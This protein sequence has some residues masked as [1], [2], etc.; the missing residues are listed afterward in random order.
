M[1]FSKSTIQSFYIQE[2]LDNDILP[3]LELDY[4]VNMDILQQASRRH[5]A[6]YAQ[7]NPEQKCRRQLRFPKAVL[8]SPEESPAQ[9]ILDS[10]C[11]QSYVT[12]TWYVKETFQYVLEKYEPIFLSNSPFSKDGLIRFVDPTKPVGRKRAL[13]AQRPLLIL[14]QNKW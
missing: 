2:Y 12:F 8:C 1:K 7:M 13:S 14:D 11:D 10:E 5:K 4:C 9:R 3:I 6:W